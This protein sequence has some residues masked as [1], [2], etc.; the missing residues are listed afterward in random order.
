MS[1]KGSE[2][3]EADGGRRRASGLPLASRAPWHCGACG[4]GL[5]ATVLT[6]THARRREWAGDLDLD[7]GTYAEAV[8]EAPGLP[9]LLIPEA[10]MRMTLIDL[11]RQR[12]RGRSAPH[13]LLRII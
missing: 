10:H 1:S 12:G 11:K 3:A 7:T 13:V 8:P 5:S 2:E 9:E 6:V 4:R